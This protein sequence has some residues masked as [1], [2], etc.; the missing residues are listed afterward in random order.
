MGKGGKG[1]GYREERRKEMGKGKK[2]ME[3]GKRGK[4]EG[5]GKWMELASDKEIGRN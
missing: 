5:D 4:K 3:M 1:G 2:K